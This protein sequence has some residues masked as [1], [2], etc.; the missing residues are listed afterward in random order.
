[1]KTI[2]ENKYNLQDSDITDY[3]GKAKALIINSNNEI[4]I[5]YCYNQYFL[6]GGCKE[7]EVFDETL[8]RELLEETGIILNEIPTPF[9][10]REGYYKDW[11]EIGRNKKL[12]I[13]Y[14]IIK[15]DEKPNNNINLTEDEINGGFTLEYVPLDK[16]EDVIKENVSK[17]TDDKGIARELL[18]VL[19]IYKES[20]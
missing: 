19:K 13:V 17:Y 20:I 3:L 2:I 10:K 11:P 16:V 4:L 9:L 18:E 8:K 7:K 5:C 14:Y 1:M 12:E 6:P 15:T